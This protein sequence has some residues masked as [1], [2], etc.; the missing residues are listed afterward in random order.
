MQV[1]ERYK[2]KYVLEI[3]NHMMKVKGQIVNGNTMSNK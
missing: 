3:N 2:I 1:K